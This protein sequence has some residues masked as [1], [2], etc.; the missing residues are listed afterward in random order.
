MLSPSPAHVGA[1]ALEALRAPTEPQVQAGALE[2]LAWFP[3]SV[4][5]RELSPVVAAALSRILAASLPLGRPMPPVLRVMAELAWTRRGV[6][7]QGVVLPEA[8]GS[9]SAVS[10][11]A[12]PPPGGAPYTVVVHID[13]AQPRAG[14]LGDLELDLQTMGGPPR[15]VLI[16]SDRRQPLDGDAQRLWRPGLLRAARVA[17][18]AHLAPRS[19][20]AVVDSM[21]PRPSVMRP[22]PSDVLVVSLVSRSDAH[23]APG[24]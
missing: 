1:I 11:S 24:V 12:A 15:L 3:E 18:Q 17:A 6:L 16:R 9:W 14:W 21:A 13:C 10:V 2:R 20:F 22:V 8:D 23:G 7:A 19:R 5:R 4:L